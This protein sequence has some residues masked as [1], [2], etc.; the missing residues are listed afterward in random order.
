MVQPSVALRPADSSRGGHHGMAQP[1]H[2]G[3]AVPRTGSPCVGHL[4]GTRRI[5]SRQVH[6]DAALLLSICNNNNIIN[7]QAIYTQIRQGRKCT[8][9]M[10][11]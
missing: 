2:L 11:V 8:S 3:E 9:S 6:C 1:Q 4:A 7:N 5:P 10:C